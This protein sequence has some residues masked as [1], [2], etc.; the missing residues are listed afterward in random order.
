MGRLTI[1]TFTTFG[2]TSDRPRENRPANRGMGTGPRVAGGVGPQDGDE[3]GVSART[4][5]RPGVWSASRPGHCHG[6]RPSDAAALRDGGWWPASGSPR[7]QASPRTRRAAGR[8]LEAPGLVARGPKRHKKRALPA[9]GRGLQTPAPHSTLPGLRRGLPQP[10][11]H[12][13]LGGLGVCEVS[14]SPLVARPGLSPLVT[15]GAGPHVPPW[16][17]VRGGW[18]SSFRDTSPGGRGVY[19]FGT[20][21]ITCF[22]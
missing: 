16:S 13:F 10:A 17:R 18:V 8:G 6:G 9:S 7:N 2:A 15:R 4:N 20:L 21:F 5:R 11:H 19:H 12:H 3:N 14:R 22:K 1:A